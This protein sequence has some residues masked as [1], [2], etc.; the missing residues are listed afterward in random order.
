MSSSRR[1][2]R[3]NFLRGIGTAGVALPFLESLPERSAWAQSQNPVFAFFICTSCGVVQRWGNEPEKFWPSSVGP[4]STQN[5]QAATDRATSILADYADRLLIV[6]GVRYPYP[7][8]G[9]GHALGL[10][11]CLTAS[12]PTG[13][14]QNATSTGVSADTVI[15]E[16]VNPPGVEPLTLYSGLKGGYID[17]KLSFSAAGRV[18]AAEGNPYNVYQRLAGLLQPGSGEPTGT[19]D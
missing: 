11:Q 1:F 8:T 9:C 10:V 3:R 4:L 2:N 19:A 6:R 13:D 12:R 15:A 7:G 16:G 14:A 18:R 5:M 17:E